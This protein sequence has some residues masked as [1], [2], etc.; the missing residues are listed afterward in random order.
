MLILIHGPNSFE[1][2]S[3]LEHMKSLFLKKYPLAGAN[4]ETINF[5]E[6]EWEDVKGKFRTLG[7][8]VEKRFLAIKGYFS[9]KTHTPTEKQFMEWFDEKDENIT[10]VFVEGKMSDKHVGWCTAKKALVFFCKELD[11]EGIRKWIQQQVRAW[12]GT[13]DDRAAGLLALRYGND[14][15]GLENE[16]LKL[17]HYSNTVITLSAVKE[18][19]RVSTDQIVFG[20]L[21]AL[22]AKRYDDALI[23]GYDL[24]HN[25]E[26]M[27]YL[28]TLLAG[29]FRDL[30][31]I[32]E[33]QSLSLSQMNHSLPIHPYRLKKLAESLRFFS[34]SSLRSTLEQ[35]IEL[36][37]SSKRVR[38]KESLLFDFISSL[39]DEKPS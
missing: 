22:R 25:G 3:K 23:G 37:R 28:T 18:W 12:D 17:F 7:L 35:I 8:F 1:V 36:D 21:D 27:P 32:Q 39:L 31:L 11:Q 34:K 5:N 19:E 9:S 14:L 24:L 13:I 29:E 20:W 16:L 30:L 38:S 15:W 10:C 33:Q 6:S 2:T 26:G 4:S